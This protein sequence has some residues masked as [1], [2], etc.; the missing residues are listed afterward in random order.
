MRASTSNGYI[1]NK[2]HS[3]KINEKIEPHGMGGLSGVIKYI[4]FLKPG[5]IVYVTL[6]WDTEDEVRSNGKDKT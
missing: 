6:N 1:V 2:N 4:K 5:S 3:I